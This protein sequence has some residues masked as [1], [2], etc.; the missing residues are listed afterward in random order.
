MQHTA[1]CK[2]NNKTNDEMNKN[3]I[4]IQRGY[5]VNIF[6]DG[7]PWTHQH[8]LLTSVAT[9][10]VTQVHILTVWRWMNLFQ[11]I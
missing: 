7:L 11:Y 9:A 8:M 2:K 5:I 3:W 6:S 1:K 4:P 10:D